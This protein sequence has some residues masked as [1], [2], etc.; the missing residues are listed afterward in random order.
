[1][2][3]VSVNKDVYC[4]GSVNVMGHRQAKIWY[5]YLTQNKVSITIFKKLIYFF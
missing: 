4:T 1:M 3:R 5:K 2:F